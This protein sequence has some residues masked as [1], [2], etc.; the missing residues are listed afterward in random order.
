[1][2]LSIVILCWNDREII[3]DCIA[4]IYAT[5][6]AT[7]FEIIVSDNGSTDESI[8]FIR[9]KFPQVRLIENGRNLR[10]AKGNNV[11]IRESHGEYVLILNPDTIIHEGTLDKLMVYADEHPKA[12]AFGCRV[13]NAD[14]SYQMSVRPIYTVRSEWC[15]A[16]GLRPLA[17]LSEWFHP[18]EY[19]GW[20]GTSEREVGWIVGCF[21]VVR[22]ELLKS[23]G[24]FDE[25]FFYYYE[26]QDLCR[27]VWEAGYPNLFTPHV[28]ITH[29]GGQSTQSK[30]PPLGF[31][32]DSYVTRYLYYYKYEGASGVRS[33]RRAILVS[34]V[35]RLVLGGIAQIVS[36]SETGKKRQNLRRALLD[37]NYRVDP[38]RLV[39]KG[40]EPEME[41]QPVG[42]V[43]ER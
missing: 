22:G 29:L 19:V 14:G 40:E 31:A 28:T 11:A 8:E 3:S 6:H 39:E 21:L 4:S 16:L 36:P 43:Q 5:T 30:F 9:K 10:F 35:L 13:L 15:L 37:W 25:Q 24:G 38:V 17:R 33:A 27:R 26:D 41:V 18:G 20:K 2:K 12:G 1:M 42:R 34:L 23:L 7:D 32:I